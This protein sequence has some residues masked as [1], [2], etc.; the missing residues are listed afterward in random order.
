MLLNMNGYCPISIEDEKFHPQHIFFFFCVPHINY[1]G[2]Y[3]Q[4]LTFFFFKSSCCFPH[5]MKKK[6]TTTKSFKS[7]EK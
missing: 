7:K 5:C 3:N 2:L 1:F 4:K 6:K